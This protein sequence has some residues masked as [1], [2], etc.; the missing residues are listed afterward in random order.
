MVRRRKL[1]ESF[2]VKEALKRSAI[3][4]DE[5]GMSLCPFHREEG[6]VMKHYEELNATA[7]LNPD[8]VHYRK[9]FEPIDLVSHLFSSP[10]VEIKA[11]AEELVIRE[12][13]AY[14]ATGIEPIYPTEEEED[15][16]HQMYGERLR[17]SK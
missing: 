8:C 7:C 4:V 16:E 3:E 17:E 6:N 11:F 12:L 15:Y 10:I 14:R 2:T 9:I 13:E 1:I 5:T